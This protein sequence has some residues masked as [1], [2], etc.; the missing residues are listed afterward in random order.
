MPIPLAAVS[1]HVAG[2]QAEAGPRNRVR[3]I[4]WAG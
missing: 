4:G 2:V 1:A 3:D